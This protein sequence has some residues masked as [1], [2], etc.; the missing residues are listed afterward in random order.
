MPTIKCINTVFLYV[1][2][3]TEMRRFYE[4]VLGLGK[5]IVNTDL[6]VEY[7]LPGSHFALHQGD[8]RILEDQVPIKNTVKFSFEV[9][10]LEAFSKQL[11]RQGV[12]FVFGPR[13]DFGSLLAEIVDA[14]GNPIRLVQKNA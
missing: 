8:A 6:W 3:M 10:D 11:T 5:P 4:S 7:E 2:N 12:E 14:E 1:K 13:K 9:D